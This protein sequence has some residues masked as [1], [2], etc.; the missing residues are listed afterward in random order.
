MMWVK[1]E[2]ISGAVWS[3]FSSKLNMFAVT[4][5]ELRYLAVRFSVRKQLDY[6]KVICRKKDLFTGVVYLRRLKSN[7]LQAGILEHIL[8][9]LI[10]I[11]GYG[12]EQIIICDTNNGRV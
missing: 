3:L 11:S 12:T 4:A 6:C 8:A 5:E 1:S 10:M 7:L 2:N 9:S